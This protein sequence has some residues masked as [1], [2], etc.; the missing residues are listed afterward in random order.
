MPVIDGKPISVDNDDE[1]HKNLIRRQGKN[2]P[3]D[4]TSKI[5][6]SIPIGQLQQFNRKMGDQGPMVQ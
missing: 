5:F 3:N 4:N 1:H 6:V 2:D